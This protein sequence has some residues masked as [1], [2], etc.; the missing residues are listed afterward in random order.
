MDTLTD[1]V[2]PLTGHKR[3]F[4]LMRVSGL[5]S[6][7]AMNLIGVSR[8]TYNS[9][10][11]NDIFSAIYSQIPDL[12]IAYRD[13]AIQLLRR[14]N[15]LEA[16]ILEG[17]MIRKIAE[18]LD[19][20]D[21][22]F[23]RTHVAREVYNKLVS[24]LDKVPSLNVKEITWEQKIFGLIT[25]QEQIEEGKTID[26]EFEEVGIIETEHQ[27]GNATPSSEPTSDEA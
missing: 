25:P 6:N 7:I 16:V 21:L 18:E 3:T 2:K 17:K 13:E 14:G 11:K 12:I 1:I 23:T 24:D 15:Q 5:D 19:T 10:F 9:W 4:V 27:E 8:G 26:G 22:K 20:G